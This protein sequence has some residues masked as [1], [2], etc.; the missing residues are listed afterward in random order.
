MNPAS[1]RVTRGGAPSFDPQTA[2]RAVDL[3]CVQGTDLE[4][5]GQK[6]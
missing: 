6:R 3:L 1:H 2:N 4:M 5:T